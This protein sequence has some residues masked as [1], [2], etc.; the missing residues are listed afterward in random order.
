MIDGS[1]DYLSMVLDRHSVVG[2]RI[3]SGPRLLPSS[4]VPDNCGFSPSLE[5][6]LNRLMMSNVDAVLGF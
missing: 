4:T 5:Q 6:S 3:W 1:I 2:W